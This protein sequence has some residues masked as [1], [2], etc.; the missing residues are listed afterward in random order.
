MNAPLRRLT[1][2][3]ALAFLA[4]VVLSPRLWLSSRSFPLV[5]PL[6]WFPPVPPP[7]DWAWF[8][9]LL[10]LLVAIV[11]FPHARRLLV[12][13][14]VLMVLYCL[15]D[16]TRW[17]PWVYE[18]LV[19]LAVLACGPRDPQDSARRNACLNACRLVVAATY[20]WSGVAKLN[21][22]FATEVFPWLM[23]PLLPE[24]VCYSLAG[25]Q[26]PVVEIGLGVGLLLGPLRKV[27]VCL[28]VMMHVVIL[29]CLGPLGHNWNS[30]V[31]PWNVA[32]AVLVVLLFW[33]CRAAPLAILWPPNF[34]VARVVLLLFGV[35]PSLN[36]VDY[37]DHYLSMS[38]YSGNIPDAELSLGA[39][40]A[41]RL[42]EHVQPLVTEGDDGR[43]RLDLDGWC[44]QELNVPA[45]PQHRFYLALARRVADLVGP[46]ADVVLVIHQRPD[47]RSGQRQELRHDLGPEAQGRRP[48]GRNSSLTLCSACSAA[49]PADQDGAAFFWGGYSDSI[50]AQ[51]VSTRSSNRSPISRSVTVP[52][53]C[54][55]LRTNLPKLKPS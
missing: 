35:L 7:L 13:F 46:D 22:S 34:P 50:G 28:A 40:A 26:P 9:A 25:Y 37:W 53:R 45:Y 24:W 52:V 41:A 42:P 33:R 39:D 8:A 31:W 4:G 55:K 18:Y 51:T 21:V 15:G 43:H 6:G 14:L 32:S 11:L 27:A 3:V 1:I 20:F 5:P 12:A 38:L 47:R 54:G 17:Q 30:V 48:V 16:Q 29:V 2:V 23:Q 10:L 49:V 19:L 44:I 36:V